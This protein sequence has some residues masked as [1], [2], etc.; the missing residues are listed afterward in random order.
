MGAQRDECPV[1]HRCPVAQHLRTRARSPPAFKDHPSGS[2][3]MVGT[4]ASPP[5]SHARVLAV[6]CVVCPPAVPSP[7]P[8]AVTC[9]VVSVQGPC[10]HCTAHQARGAR[11][12]H[13]P[14]GDAGPP[15]ARQPRGVA[16]TRLLHAA[17]LE[18]G[19]PCHRQGRRTPRWQARQVGQVRGRPVRPVAHMG[20][21]RGAGVHHHHEGRRKGRLV[22][23]GCC[24]GG[25][26]C[27]HG[28][29]MPSARAA[30]A[31]QAAQLRFTAHAR[32]CVCALRC[33]WST[34]CTPSWSAT[35]EGASW[36][37]P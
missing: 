28:G 37:V 32:A 22:A 23:T 1:V 12:L 11:R 29:S 30:C 15:C 26:C 20:R 19:Q 8:A 13:R 35:T 5:A 10:A 34:G 7:S 25:E 24:A 27:V 16:A 31:G 4:H 9:N 2:N 3:C 14:G 18:T 21:H 33:R 17:T 6:P 36:M